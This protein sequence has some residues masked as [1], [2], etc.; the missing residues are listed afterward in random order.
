MRGEIGGFCSWKTQEIY[1]FLEEGKI[2]QLGGNISFSPDNSWIFG[3][4]LGYPAERS[5][6][7]IGL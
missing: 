7:D 5:S 6:V 2:A 4:V 3:A 1:S